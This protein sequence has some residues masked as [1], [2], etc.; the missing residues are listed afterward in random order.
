MRGV[1][2]EDFSMDLVADIEIDGTEVLSRRL[3]AASSGD[4]NLVA[5]GS[6]DKMKLYKALLTANADITGEVILKLGSVEIGGVRN[7][8]IGGQYILLSS[9]PDYALGGEGDDLVVNLPG[10]TAVTIN[11]SYEVIAA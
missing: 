10:T 11:V 5:V 1:F 6:G 2:G 7:P 3:T 8:R 9:F 4:N